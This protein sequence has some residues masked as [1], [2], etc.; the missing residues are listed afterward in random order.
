MGKVKTLAGTFNKGLLADLQGDTIDEDSDM[1][2]EPDSD[3]SVQCAQES[4]EN[5]L[6]K[7]RAIP[8]PGNHP[9]TSSDEICNLRHM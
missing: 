3:D 7:I 1:R 4:I 6:T 9:Q 5:V 2:D 8:Q